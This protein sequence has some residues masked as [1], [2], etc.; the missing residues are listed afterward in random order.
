MR[1]ATQALGG[2]APKANPLVPA[3]FVIDHSVIADVFGWPDVCERNVNF[4]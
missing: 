2:D 3:E 4:G 1:E